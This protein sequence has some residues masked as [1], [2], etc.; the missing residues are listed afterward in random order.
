MNNYARSCWLG[1][2]IVTE[3][4]KENKEEKNKKVTRRSNSFG[5]RKTPLTYKT[6]YIVLDSSRRAG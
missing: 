4:E 6:M 2:G 1:N 3:E 5:Q